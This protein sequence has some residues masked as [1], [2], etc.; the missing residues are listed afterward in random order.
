MAFEIKQLG[1]LFERAGIRVEEGVVGID[2]G[3]SSIKVV[4]LGVGKQGA[5]L[6]TYGELQLGPYANSDIGRAANLDQKKLIE[7]IV[8]IVREA[9][10]KSRNA[11]LAIPYTASFVIVIKIPTRDQTQLG[12]M[13]PI[14]ARK[15]VPIPMNEV[16]LDWFVIPEAPAAAPK[17][18]P[19]TPQPTD[20]RVLLAVIH[21][22]ALGRYQSVVQS[23][24]LLSSFS[25]IE[26]FSVIRSS[27]HENDGTVMLLDIGAGSAK[28]YI[29][30]GGILYETHR[31]AHGGE[32]LT[33]TLKDTLG[34]SYEEAEEAKR[35]MGLEA[36]QYDPRIKQAMSKVLEQLCAESKRV[37]TRFETEQGKVVE[38]V[39]LAGGGALLKG[40]VP[41]MNEKLEKEVVI[42]DPFSKVEYPAFLEE[43]LTEAGPSFAVAMG[44]ALRRLSE[45]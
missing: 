39:I 24:G 25:E 5:A 32:A 19:T 2:I 45:K 13:V 27:V 31:T 34:L 6:E 17:D 30:E 35:Q 41:F 1:K 40:L 29:V 15:Y 8:D 12:S 4:Q 10:V 33:T 7:A 38:K 37:L 42:A 23:A 28:L 44:V 11:A 20:T 43:T 36:D 3:A 9:G 26:T 21:N 22:E 18:A 14:E 16:T